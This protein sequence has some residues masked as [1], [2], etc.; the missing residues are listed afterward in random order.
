MKR[1]ISRFRKVILLKK[2][3]LCTAAFFLSV[4][5]AAPGAAYSADPAPSSV[6]P[7]TNRIESMDKK[8]EEIKEDQR[9]VLENQKEILEQMQHLK[10]LIRRS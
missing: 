6:T 4:F 2:P 5:A 8:L 10:V 1:K 3:K 9:Q 7:I